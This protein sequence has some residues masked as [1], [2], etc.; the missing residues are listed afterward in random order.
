MEQKKFEELLEDLV[1]EK[2]DKARFDFWSGYL[3]GL[4]DY[5]ILNEVE[6][7]KA[8]DSINIKFLGV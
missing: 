6:Y 2:G 5:G 3:Y 1:Q 7:L 8:K 4:L